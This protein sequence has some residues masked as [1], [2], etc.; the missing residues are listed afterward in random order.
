[1]ARYVDRMHATPGARIP[2][3][4]LSIGAALVAVTGAWLWWFGENTANQV[5]RTND[6]S[7]QYSVQVWVRRAHSVST[8]LLIGAAVV[9][10]LRAAQRRYGWQ[11]VYLLAFLVFAAV[12]VWSGLGADWDAARLWSATTGSKLAVGLPL[13]DS[14]PLPTPLDDARLHL[15]I[16]PAVLLATAVL[17]LLQQRRS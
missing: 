14:P 3:L 4:V 17:A 9:M 5:V 8:W 11:V 1:M 7:D 13:D 12:A 15:S 2:E 16:V 10:V 6:L